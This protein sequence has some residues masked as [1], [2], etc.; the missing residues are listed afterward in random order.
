MAGWVIIAI[1][2]I[3]VWGVLRFN[4]DHNRHQT[5]DVA[6]VNEAEQALIEA[7]RERDELR[8]RVQVLE[9]IVT[10]NNMP[11]AQKTK[12]IEAEIEALRDLETRE[13]EK[14]PVRKLEDQGK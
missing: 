4:R 14:A 11:A 12:Q 1:V 5:G 2:A 6:R 8:E 9:R 3:L 10:D 13:A 7:T